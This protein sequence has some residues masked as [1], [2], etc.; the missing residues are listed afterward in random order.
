MYVQ[1][2]VILD[3][4]VRNKVLTS[5]KL[6]TIMNECCRS[7]L[8]YHNKF[9]SKHGNTTLQN[10]RV[11]DDDLGI[12]VTLYTKKPIHKETS[13]EKHIDYDTFFDSY[14]EHIQYKNKHFDK[15]FGLYKKSFL[16]SLH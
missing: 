13:R 4:Y 12:V 6:Y 10:F 8:L 15:M 2:Q 1:N 3:H 9:D 5:Y 11:R 14:Y 16:D 7:I